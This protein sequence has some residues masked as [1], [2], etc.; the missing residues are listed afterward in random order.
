MKVLHNTPLISEGPC[1][2]ALNGMFLHV[3]NYNYKSSVIA[4][5]VRQSTNKAETIPFNMGIDNK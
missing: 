1:Q 3:G 4:I 5:Q 2:V